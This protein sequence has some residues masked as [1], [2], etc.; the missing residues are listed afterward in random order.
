MKA[1]LYTRVSTEDQATEGFSLS[2][3][4]N[5]LRKYCSINNIEI[6]KVY[7]DEGISGQKENRPEFQKMISDAEKKLFNVILVHKYDRFAR[8]VELSQRIK[9]KLK[10]TGINVIS[11]TEPIEDSPMGFFVSGLHDLLAEYY[12]KNLALESKKGHIERASQG[13]HNGSVPYGYKRGE[14]KSIVFNEEQAAIVRKIYHLY[15]HEGYGCTKIAFW[16]N[17]QGI[18]TA[19][20]GGEWNHF[21]VNRILKNVKYIGKIEYDGK[22]YDGHHEPIISESEFDLVKKNLLDRTWK[23]EYRGINFEKFLLL[24]ITW[25]GE[26][27]HVFSLQNYYTKGRTRK[28]YYK[29]NNNV[30]CGKCT[31]HKI[32]R[33]E[34]LENHIISTLEKYMTGELQDINFVKEQ[35]ISSIYENRKARIEQ[36]LERAKSAYLENVFSLD[37]YKT[38]RN[39]A[40]IELKEIEKN[41]IQEQNEENNKQLIRNK[42]KTAWDA[43][44][45]EKNIPE[46][47]AILKQFVSKITVR[48]DEIRIIFKL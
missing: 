46:K 28:A 12:V 39:K 10:T 30:H 19:I 48:P 31:H 43:F 24:G 14:G 5:E 9:N 38:I 21:T 40:E 26:C 7:S 44:I 2:A 27:G 3:Q 15:N 35:N 16:L 17:R 34:K 45:N 8:K 18:S 23:R 20:P 36:E 42:I 47:R 37:E 6:H 13:Y 33:V 4:L 41:E 25:C 29:C 1:A 22:V 11:I 32:Y